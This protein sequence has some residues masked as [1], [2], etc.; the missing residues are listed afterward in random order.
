MTASSSAAY[1]SLIEAKD[2]SIPKIASDTLN[3]QACANYVDAPSY[4]S[5]RGGLY[6]IESHAVNLAPHLKNFIGS[7]APVS[8]GEAG[9]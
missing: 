4:A 5:L 7:P 2:G 8:A 9:R 1:V 6:C 3:D